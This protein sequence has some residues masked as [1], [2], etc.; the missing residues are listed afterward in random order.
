MGAVQ[1]AEIVAGFAGGFRGTGAQHIQQEPIVS[2]L[3]FDRADVPG[4]AGCLGQFGHADR[5]AGD[6]IDRRDQTAA[7]FLDR[8][9]HHTG[10]RAERGAEF[11]AVFRTS[12]DDVAVDVPQ[13]RLGEH[14][15]P[16]GLLLLMLAQQIVD[17]LER[18]AARMASENGI[19][20]S[21]PFTAAPPPIRPRG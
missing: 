1:E 12:R 16:A 3:E 19:T 9:R 4:Q 20:P 13:R 8:C 11:E 10:G 14:D 2:G 21:C 7:I 15:V 6:V 18:H 17:L 5:L